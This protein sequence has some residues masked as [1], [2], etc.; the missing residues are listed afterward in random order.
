M[1]SSLAWEERHN[2]VGHPRPAIRL[3]RPVRLIGHTPKPVAVREAI[4]KGIFEAAKQGERDPLRLRDAG[5]NPMLRILMVKKS[6]NERL[7]IYASPDKG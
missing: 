6:S 2:Q 3:G 4:A 5:L 1:L 7:C